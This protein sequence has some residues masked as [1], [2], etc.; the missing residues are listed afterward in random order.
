MISVYAE[1]KIITARAGQKA[2]EF[3]GSAADYVL[4][5]DGANG[6]SRGL[7]PV[8]GNYTL[9]E[10]DSLFVTKRGVAG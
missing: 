2:A 7:S 10:G 1:G 4:R 5:S 8:D 3:G 6:A 9:Q